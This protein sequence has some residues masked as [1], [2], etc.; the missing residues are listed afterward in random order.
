MPTISYH[1]FQRNKQII[2]NPRNTTE[3]SI[4]SVKTIYNGQ[5]SLSSLGPRYGICC[6]L[7][8]KKLN[9]YWSLK[10]KLMVGIQQIVAPAEFVK[11]AYVMLDMSKF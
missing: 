5:E 2:Y 10:S 8:V 9:P 1:P 6:Q 4:L 7:N 3:F 11:I